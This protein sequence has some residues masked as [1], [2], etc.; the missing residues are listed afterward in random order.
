MKYIIDKTVN[1]VTSDKVQI[2]NNKGYT[3]PAGVSPAPNVPMS[4]CLSGTLSDNEEI[5]VEYFD[6]TEWFPLK[7]NGAVVNLNVDNNIISIYAPLIMRFVKSA[8]VN[9][10]GLFIVTV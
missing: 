3:L 9:P 6:G 8:T 2:V 1:E 5:V 7:I 4:F 10:V